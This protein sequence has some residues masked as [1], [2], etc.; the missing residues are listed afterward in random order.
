MRSLASAYGRRLCCCKIGMAR[1]RL[2]DRTKAARVYQIVTDIRHELSK[3]WQHLSAIH[4][5]PQWLWSG[6]QSPR[7]AALVVSTR[8]AHTCRA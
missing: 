4:S 6:F 3:Q 5:A 7:P 1:T 8:P 2:T